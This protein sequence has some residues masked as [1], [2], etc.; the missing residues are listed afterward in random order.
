M[1]F[2][3]SHAFTPPQPPLESA[4]SSATKSSKTTMRATDSI[5]H[6]TTAADALCPAFARTVR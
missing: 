6:R 3:C 2:A 5:H 1:N 4:K